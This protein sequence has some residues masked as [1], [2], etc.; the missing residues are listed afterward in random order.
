MM[1]TDIPVVNKRLYDVLV[2]GMSINEQE[3]E[4]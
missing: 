4:Q 2:F 1:K 3:H